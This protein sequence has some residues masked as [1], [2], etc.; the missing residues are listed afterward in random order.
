[1][2]VL[3]V[4]SQPEAQTRQPDATLGERRVVLSGPSVGNIP[5]Q[6]K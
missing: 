3:G 4:S 1:M 6:Q 2:A 5:D